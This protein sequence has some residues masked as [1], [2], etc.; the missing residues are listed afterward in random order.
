MGVF[1][2]T[3]LGAEGERE[4]VTLSCSVSVTQN[5]ET[6]LFI[7]LSRNGGREEKFRVV[8]ESCSEN[9]TIGSHFRELP[10][11]TIEY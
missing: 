11:L 7:G 8:A 10:S 5:S 1:T 3:L 6:K 4:Q 2:G 9:L